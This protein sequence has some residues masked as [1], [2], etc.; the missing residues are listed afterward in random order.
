MFKD[1]IPESEVDIVKEVKQF[2]TTVYRYFSFQVEE[3]V[4]RRSGER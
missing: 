3:N 4:P 1:Q 2:R